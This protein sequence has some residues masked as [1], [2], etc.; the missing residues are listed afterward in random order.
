MH[1]GVVIDANIIPKFY[2]EL[3]RATGFLYGIVT[4]LSHNRGIAINEHIQA[5]WT[6]VCSAPI[7]LDWY[8]DELKNGRIRKINSQPV[9]R[10]VRKK[11]RI[12]FGFLCNPIDL[13]YIECAK[14]TPFTK[15]IMTEDHDFYDP[16]CKRKT[17]Q[18][19]E[20]AREQ[21]KGAFCCFLLG[22]LGIRVGMPVHCK[23]DF[24]IP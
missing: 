21:R 5:E 1:D 2:R 3:S 17:K 22:V 18:T 4:W 11:M 20:R 13:R 19:R 9:P 16:R 23:T 6:N 8:T 15:Y 24:S 12:Q 14:A 10:D 7:F